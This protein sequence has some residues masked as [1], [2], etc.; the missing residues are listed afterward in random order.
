MSVLLDIAA[1]GL[2]IALGIGLRLFVES[3][4]GPA[5]GAVDRCA[6]VSCTG[7]C[8]QPPACEQKMTL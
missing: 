4:R 6:V 1:A 3:R 5:P 7:R 2:L 8:D